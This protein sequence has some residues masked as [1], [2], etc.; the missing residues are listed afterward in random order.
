[1]LTYAVRL[2]FTQLTGKVGGACWRM[3][4]SACLT[5]GVCR[6]PDVC[7]V[8]LKMKTSLLFFFFAI[9][10]AS[11]VS[12]LVR[13]RTRLLSKLEDEGVI[14]REMHCKLQ[15]CVCGVNFFFNFFLHSV[16]AHYFFVFLFSFCLSV[17][18]TH[19]QVFTC[20]HV[21]FFIFFI[22]L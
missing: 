17:S 14:N 11:P 18:F 4:L 12:K 10:S 19:V 7:K 13:E 8:S 16:R 6:I 2:G 21:Y 1:M 9:S 22:C 5:Y 3:P 15:V 20:I